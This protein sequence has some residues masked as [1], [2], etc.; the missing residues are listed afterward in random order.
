MERA[1]E[2]KNEKL[3]TGTIEVK[4]EA[5]EILN[6]CKPLPFA[7]T[8]SGKEIDENLRLKYRFVDM[9]RKRVRDHIERRSDVLRFVTDWY[10][11]KGFTQVQTP[12]LT[13][14]SPEGARDFLVPSRLYP[15]KFYALPQAPQQYKQLLMVGGLHKYFQIAP[16]FRD[17]D[18]RADRHYGSFYQIDTEYSFVTQEEIWESV[19][20]FF[21]DIVEKFTDKKIVQYPFARIPYNDAWDMYGSD[22]PDVRYE[23]KLIELT[24]AFKNSE[25][26]VFKQVESAK[27]IVVD[28]EFSRKE[29]DEWTE[30][31]KLQG[32][33]GLAVMNIVDGKLEGSLM[34]FFD[35]KLQTQVL[36][37]AKT[38]GYEIKGKQTLL[39]VAGI[40]RESQKQMG[41]LR[42]QMANLMNLI[43]QNKIGFAWIIDFDMFEWSETESR[44]DF[45]H[46]PFSM[47]KGG[48][49]ALK[50]QK[51]D[52]IKAQQYDLACNGYEIISGSIRNHNPE[53]FVEA[54]K[55][56]G[57]TEDDTKAKFGHM[58]S[59]FEFGAP[60][61]GGYAIGIDR[62]MMTL[63]DEENIREMYAF[64]M[65]SNGMEIMM[66][67][68]REVD[69]KDLDVL[70]IKLADK[71]KEVRETIVDRLN[72]VGAKFEL[73]E[74][75][76][77][78]TSEEAAN[79]RGTKLSEGAKAIIL[80]SLDYTTKYIQVV[81]PADK[82]LDL[83]KVEQVTGEK[84]E[85]GKTEDVEK[86][87]G[88]KVGAIPPF[89]RLLGVELY[90]DRAFWTKDRVAFNVGS[91]DKSIIM[92]AV[93]LIKAAEPNKV[94]KD[95][96]FTV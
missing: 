18:P 54:F 90:F 71:G 52:E 49:N 66:N 67:A 76:E 47:P 89:G 53:V 57:Y 63:F 37:A 72:S 65:G 64:P 4:A 38:A 24:D 69:K 14:S 79:V 1:L 85:L 6:K 12:L 42:V 16:C 83:K 62:F 34:K 88:L 20:P 68:P 25:M 31:M 74:H 59:A 9:R 73:V 35:E 41:W 58:I 39:A 55:I 95:A 3:P 32:A 26:Q 2:A 29:I 51:P 60:P 8:E 27:A 92:Q 10:T 87:T 84:Y 28:R 56:C 11:D 43:D 78:R 5:L 86:L 61:H 44:W 36:E 80:H 96:D 77:V 70:S 46:N 21:K 30:K 82:Q 91:R 13:V 45:M 48:L 40:K 81:V 15:G 7:L 75:E 94:S 19:E 50:T 17:E 93:D 23:L 22:K 33:K